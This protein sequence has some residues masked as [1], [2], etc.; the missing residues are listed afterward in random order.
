MSDLYLVS[1]WSCMFHVLI[2]SSVA[3]PIDKAPTFLSKALIRAQANVKVSHVHVGL[4][5]F[6]L[7]TLC[8]L[9]FY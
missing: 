8:W 6:F 1:G 5:V 2:L 7:I 3:D 4:H 9:L